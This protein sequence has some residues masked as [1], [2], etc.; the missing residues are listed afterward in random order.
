MMPYKHP[1][2][3]W[4][5]ETAISHNTLSKPFEALEFFLG[6]IKQQCKELRISSITT[7][8]QQNTEILSLVQ[9]LSILETRFYSTVCK[10]DSKWPI[11][12]STKFSILK[13]TQ[14]LDP[15][16]FAES[17]T[18]HDEESFLKI[19]ITDLLS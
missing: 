16:N 7:V 14:N 6:P 10:I 13:S 17:N 2:V 15:Q 8:Q 19:S 9:K 1:L 4:M 18:K 5:L 11:R 12:F 3:R